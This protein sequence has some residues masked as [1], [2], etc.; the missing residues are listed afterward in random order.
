MIA[1]IQ[2]GKAA[3]QSLHA[4]VAP[5]QIFVVDTRDLDLPA[6]RRLHIGRDTDHIIVIEIKPRHGIIALRLCRLLLYGKRPAVLVKLHHAVLSGIPHIVAEDRRP[7]FSGSHLAK[8]PGK[9]LPIENII[10]QHERHPVIPDKIRPDDKS[11]RQSSR[12]FLHGIFHPQAELFARS[13]QFPKGRK[14]SRC[15]YD[16]D[17]PDPCQHKYGQR[18]VDHRFIVNRHNLLGD[19]LCQRIQP[20]A[21][22]ARKNNSLHE[23]HPIPL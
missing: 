6:R 14:V 11:V 4:Q 2:P 7:F 18:I 9:A 19:C 23:S 3:P 15:G 8:H 17:L 20:C 10:P 16:Q 1:R 5:A 21:R 13:E 22:A 12:V